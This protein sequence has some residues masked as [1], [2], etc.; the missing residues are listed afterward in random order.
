MAS[1]RTTTNSTRE[2]TRALPSKRIPTRSVA[3][4]SA[5]GDIGNKN[6][7]KEQDAKKTSS[8]L[9]VPNKTTA[10]QQ[11]VVPRIEL[12]EVEEAVSM[13]DAT[14]EMDSEPTFPEGVLD[15]DA[16][17]KENPQLCAEYAPAM[18]AYLRTIEEGLVI[19]K[20]F[21]KGCSVNGK[22]RGVLVDWLVEVHTQF[23][24]LQETLYMTIY[25]I[26]KYLQVEG[27]TIKRNKLQ[28][29]GVSA[30]FIASKVE[31][32][33][34]PEIND[35]V[36]I[37][38]NA[39]SAGEI[40]QMELKLLNT[41]AFNFSRPL[42]LHFLRRNSK[43]GDVDVLQHTVAKYLVEVSLL[44]YELAHY[45]P[46]LMA[47]AALFLSLRV[48]E[49]NA[50]LA[51]VWTPT[52]QHYS[53]YNTRELLPLV[54]KLSQAILKAKEGKLQAVHTKYMSKKFMKVGDL[55]DLRGEVVTKLAKKELE[56]L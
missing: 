26:D 9:P 5:L 20:D 33:Y 10:K 39:Y 35:F 45:P 52:L 29:V 53:T 55:S 37:T 17:D 18:Y 50:T 24:L 38:D 41:L 47:A 12:M 40:R 36:Y 31:E 15:I 32:M 51:T 22:M 34:A 4:R 2:N 11:S 6:L 54:C 3:S 48:L 14:V 49:P 19:K 8:S 1:L 43:A 27:L 7:A 25:I 30:M 28:L 13:M 16:Q 56:G 23:K 42:P 44:E 21:L 46:S